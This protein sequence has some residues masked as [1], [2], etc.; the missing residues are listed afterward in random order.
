MPSNGGETFKQPLKGAEMVLDS[1]EAPDNKIKKA[2]DVLGGK[3]KEEKKVEREE[4]VGDTIE[5]SEEDKKSYLRTLLSTERF[6]KEYALFGGK[7]SVKFQTRTVKENERINT[8]FKG[9]TIPEKT[10]E[11]HRFLTS[12]VH[13]TI[14]GKEPIRGIEK[15]SGGKFDFSFFD[16]MDDVLYYAL[17]HAFRQFEELCDTLFRKAN[18]ANFWTGTGGAT[19]RSA[20][21][22]KAT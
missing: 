4:I 3:I 9:V 8:V 1:E 10:R 5:V 13:L 14:E 18:D 11:M 17:L 20:H 16:D 21:S 6:N 2:A 12:M 22:P 15:R 7:I 19:S